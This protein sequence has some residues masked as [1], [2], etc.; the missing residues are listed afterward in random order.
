MSV[1]FEHKTYTDQQAARL[2]WDVESVMDLMNRR[3]YYQMAGRHRQEL[4]DLWV[5][6]PEHRRTPVWAPTTDIIRAW[7]RWSGSM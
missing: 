6:E 3:V 1:C 2:L 4:E 7:T 5:T